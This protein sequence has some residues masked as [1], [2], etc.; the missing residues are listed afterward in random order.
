[1][2]ENRVASSSHAEIGK[3]ALTYAIFAGLWILL[4][5]KVVAWLFNDPVFIEVAQTL[6]G[7]LFVG[8]TSLLLYWLL[9]RLTK[10]FGTAL[11]PTQHSGFVNIPR[12][13]QYIVAVVLT[14]LTLL[15]RYSIAASFGERT[16]LIIFMFPII[17]SAMLYGL[18]PGI[19]ST[20]TAALLAIYFI[21]PPT[22]SLA[23]A[24]SYDLFQ[25]G[26]LLTNGLLVSFLSSMLH[27]SRYKAEQ[28]RQLAEINLQEKT[29]AM[30][31]LDSIAQSS[32]DA[33]FAKDLQ[34][35]YLLFNDAAARIVGKSI[36]DVLG[37]DDSAIFPPAN[38]MTVMASDRQVMD[39]NQSI[40]FEV[41]LNTANGK[42][43]FLA[44]K[45]P[46]RD[47]DGRVIGIFGI[48]RDISEIKHFQ[49]ALS[50]SEATYRSLFENI[51]NGVVHVRMIFDGEQP[52]DYEYLSTNPAYATT[53]GITAP[54]VGRRICEII[55]GY[56]EN[57]RDALEVFG[58]VAT[59][60]IPTRWE[61]YLR[62]LDR[63]FSF[64]IYAPAYGEVIIIIENITE[65]KKAEIALREAESRYR[66][67]F[68]NNMDGVLLTHPSGDILAANAESQRIFGYAREELL[69]IKQQQL[70]E[71][72][73][74]RLFA[75]QTMHIDSSRF[76]GELTLVNKHGDTF[77]GE[78]STVLFEDE[79]GRK[80]SVVMVRDITE[81]KA[82]VE[83]LRKLS[84]AVEQ[85]P[86]SIIITD[87][88]AI[89]EYV[90]ESFLRNTGYSR[91]EIIGQNPR[92][93]HSGK[94]PHATYTAL[95]NAL[96][97]GETWHGEFINRRKDG[98]EYIEHAII[99][100]IRAPDGSVT[101]YV[102]VQE[103]ITEK[104]RSEAEIHRLAFYDTLTGL[105]NRSLL[106]ERMTQ[107][108]AMT[109]REQ[110]QSALL[111]LNIDRFKNINDAGGQPLGDAL[112]IALGER[113]GTLLREGDV[114]A[115]MAG[116]EFAI[117]LPDFSEQ[118]YR[119]SYQSMHVA[120]KIL[121]AL[122][123]PF[124]IGEN[125]ITVS[126]CLGIALFPDSEDDAP[127]DILRR[128]ATALHFAKSKGT[129][130]I[131]FF[132]GELDE[133]SKQRFDIERELRRGI[134][135]N[136]LQLYLQPQVDAEGAMV[137]AEALVRWLHPQ[138][139]LLPPVTFI[140]IAE[141]SDLIVD[142]GEWVFAEVCRLLAQNDMQRPM[143]I[144]VNISPRH[145]SQNN[146]VSWIKRMLTS[147]GVDPTRITLEITEGMVINNMHDVISKM[148]E[149]SA[150]GIHFS[151]DDFGTGYSSLSYLK[152]LP[153][154]ELK[155]DKSFVQDITIDPD[156]AA[157]VETILAVAKLMHLIVVAEGV[158][159]KEQAA[160]LNE[161][162]TV[163]HQ[164]YLFGRPE[165]A[166][167]L[168][169]K[170]VAQE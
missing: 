18:G 167:D 29:R 120:E 12:W 117:L 149:L 79:Y 147:S 55:P 48:S 130:Q 5:D 83:Q 142:I 4:S 72:A 11:A 3:I 108:L 109:R 132:E 50:K 97:K 68:E 146:F 54:V 98:S 19:V 20:F 168:F 100:P 76:R 30:Q 71:S 126:V 151:M 104:K 139:G 118:Q 47:A 125:Q 114:L 23:I 74:M 8:V 58:R 158:E 38:A 44:T 138:R 75:A 105:P 157:L 154:D 155:I 116:D 22:G 92:L 21:I 63:W 37:K 17:M 69:G 107:T 64:M 106:L 42:A 82:T 62:E 7:W 101:H 1:M 36:K 170:L 89:T 45:G 34:G 51:L 80:M 95:W 99:S 119:A 153:I 145:F 159:T 77:P 35:H 85:S 26:F 93:L 31:L 32:T 41:D 144:A 137:G 6:K 57:N 9:N 81:R 135:S 166:A 10:K 15:I 14:L 134:P 156:D 40:T 122:R 103:D 160:F 164:G 91:E 102:A 169:K 78:V 86:E 66:S 121:A 140:P 27:D 136:E 88:D 128:S 152:R 73:D 28:E 60:G 163:I 148:N 84:L 162:A 115:K 24:H 53:T 46:L 143:R 33:I 52:V 56:S 39:K 65:R 87:L 94:T 49:D 127:L 16:M 123:S 110:H 113:V 43:T 61:H 133:L 96:T 161:R 2:H 67:L 25:L 141:E 13:Q 131:A 129:G 124:Q 70:I 165:P 111:T 59:T 112:I 90:N 150:L